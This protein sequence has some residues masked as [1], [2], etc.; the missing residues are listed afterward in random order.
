MTKRPKGGIIAIQYTIK[1]NRPGS[2]FRYDIQFYDPDTGKKL[3]T[4]GE[5][6]MTLWGAKRRAKRWC[7]KYREYVR[8]GYLQNP[9]V[10][11]QVDFG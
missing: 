7:R 2:V 3:D 4:V 11:E 10:D 6:A 8:N 9:Y 5:S 1:R